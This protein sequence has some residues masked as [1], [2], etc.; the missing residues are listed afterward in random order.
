MSPIKTHATGAYSKKLNQFNRLCEKAPLSTRN[1]WRFFV[2]EL[3]VF[4]QPVRVHWQ[5]AAAAWLLKQA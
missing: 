4:C 3:A 1:G 2:P 5:L